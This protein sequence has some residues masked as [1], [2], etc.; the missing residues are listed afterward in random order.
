MACACGAAS[1]APPLPPLPPSFLSSSS[2]SPSSLGACVRCLGRGACEKSG[3][4]CFRK[5]RCF[6]KQLIQIMGRALAVMANG[7][8]SEKRRR[9]AR[10]V[11]VRERQQSCGVVVVV[12]VVAVALFL[13]YLFFHLCVMSL[14]S[15]RP[16][17]H[18]IWWCF[19]CGC[20]L[21]WA[22]ARRVPSRRQ[23]SANVHAR[24]VVVVLSMP[25]SFVPFH[26]EG[27]PPFRSIFVIQRKPAMWNPV[28]SFPLP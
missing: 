27:S 3:S 28:W 17:A 21:T 1:T 11:L 4:T 13:F 12:V 14:D 15:Y 2:A 26:N 22:K 23:P 19:F 24:V 5:G 7:L 8:S 9:A 20:D 16:L 10:P 6:V 18:A 25:V